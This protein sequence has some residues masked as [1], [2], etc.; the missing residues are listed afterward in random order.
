ML[1]ASFNTLFLNS[2]EGCCSSFLKRAA[3]SLPKPITAQGTPTIEEGRQAF[4]GDLRS[5]SGLGVADGIA[6]HTDKWL[7]VCH[8]TLSR[9]VR[10]YVDSIRSVHA[11]ICIS[12]VYSDMFCPPIP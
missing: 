12:L 5:T 2:L 8:Q 6:N 9:L 4:E 7:Q 3:G 10:E 11:F 1:R